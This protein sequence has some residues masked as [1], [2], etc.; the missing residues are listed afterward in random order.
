MFDRLPDLVND[1]AAL[2]HR[3]RFLSVDLLLQDGDEPY[4]VRIREGRIDSVER[5]PQLMRPWRFAIRADAAAWRGFWEAMPRPG[6]HD[7]FA[8]C[9]LGVA[10]VEGDLQPLMANLRYMKEV[11][12]APRAKAG[13]A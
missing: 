2:V 1:N 4:H 7:I 6:Y 11:L 12:A 9:K 10:S 13:E 3:G 8:M 5:G